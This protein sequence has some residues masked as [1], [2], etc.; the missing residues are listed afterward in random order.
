MQV[1]QIFIHYTPNSYTTAEAE[2]SFRTT[3]F[4]SEDKLI[5]IFGSAMA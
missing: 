3:E 2:I 4:G 5:R 1:T